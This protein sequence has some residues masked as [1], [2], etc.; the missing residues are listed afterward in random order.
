VNECGEPLVE[1]TSEVGY[2]SEVV[3]LES[4]AD[5]DIADN[6]DTAG[7]PQSINHSLYFIKCLSH[8]VI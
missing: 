5:L 1:Q 3:G 7:K 4:G 8:E 2:H 6:P